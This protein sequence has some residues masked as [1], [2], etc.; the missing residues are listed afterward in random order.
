[1]SQNE[2]AQNTYPIDVESGAEMARLLDLDKLFT[3][4]M[5]TLFPTSIDLAPI[6]RI[7]DIGCGP[8]GW[9]QAVANTY[10]QKRITGIDISQSMITYARAHAE[11]RKLRNAKF[12]VMN[13]IQPLK[14]LDASF[15]LVHIRAAT[16]FIL[17]HAWSTVLAECQRILSPDGLIV[18]TESDMGFANTPAMENLVGLATKALLLAGRSFAPTGRHLG[19]LPVMGRLLQAAGFRQV[20]QAAHILDYSFHAKAHEGFLQNY[21]LMFQLGESFIRKAHSMTKEEYERLSEQALLE[22]HSETFCGILVLRTL[23][24]KK[25]R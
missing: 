16:G 17:P 12:I 15:D 11:V 6:T 10:P 19:I 1:M 9:V 3:E 4:S 2:K 20:G 22:M 21:R 23:C 14:F 25:T 5:G 8:G 7:L 18:W 24:G 13:A